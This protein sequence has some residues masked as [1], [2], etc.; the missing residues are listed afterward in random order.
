M[1]TDLHLVKGQVFLPVSIF[2]RG[3]MYKGRTLVNK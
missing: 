1:T 3:G 2:L